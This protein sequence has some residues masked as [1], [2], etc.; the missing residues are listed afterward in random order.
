M[1]QLDTSLGIACLI[2]PTT[3]MVELTLAA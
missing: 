1:N 3:D 2:K